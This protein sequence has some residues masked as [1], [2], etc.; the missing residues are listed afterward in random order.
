MN[1]SIIPQPKQ[2]QIHSGICQSPTLFEEIDPGMAAEGYCLRIAESGITLTA[3]SPRG[4]IWGRSTLDQLWLQYPQALPCMTIEDEPAFPCR[5]F[6]LD[7][8]R[9]FFSMD[10]LKKM[11]TAASRFKLNHL[12]WHI[13]DDQ[14]WRIE[15]EK[16]PRLHEIGSRR[17]GDHFVRGEYSE[18]ENGGYYTKAEVRDFV[19][20]CA[21]LGIEVTPE[22]D[23]PGHV[24]AILAAYPHLSCTGEKQEVLTRGG[25]TSELLCVGNEEV[26]TFLE[27]LFDE[28]L[29]LFPG[30]YF[31]IGGDE[32]P[33]ARWMACPRCRKRLEEQGLE[34]WR[35]LQGY[36][37]NRIAAFLRSRGRRAIVWNDG[38]FGGNLD[39]D[40]IIQVW[41]GDQ[42]GALAK[43]TA[44]GGK[45]LLSPTAHC[46]HDY[47]YGTTNL[48][49]AYALNTQPEEFPAGSILGTESLSWA[50]F[51]KTNEKLEYQ[52]WPRFCATAEA[53]WCAENRPDYGN[54]ED[55]LRM[56]YPLFRELDI[57]AGTP[58]QWNPGPQETEAQVAAFH[59]NFELDDPEEYQQLLSQM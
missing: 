16:F 26:F 30:K 17:K 32:A 59:K 11:V 9:H 35:Q 36:M 23:I 5:S 2:L 55:R 7:S 57:Q 44:R 31:H 3:G 10:E 56:I 49:K 52:A 27:E 38:A 4:L 39:P 24:T 22:M 21:E 1:P 41:F 46:Y 25:I 47:P 58:E 29:E 28:L 45:L 18:E 43:H 14:G 34:T 15:S 48:Q 53:G 54:F 37:M 20:Y 6:H 12:H 8:S 19:A 13:S 50:E 51:I 40:I 42:D 33:K